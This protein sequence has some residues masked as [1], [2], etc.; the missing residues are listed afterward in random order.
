MVHLVLLFQ[1]R[2]R[3]RTKQNK[4]NWKKGGGGGTPKRELVRE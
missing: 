4:K 1:K 2:E 3:G